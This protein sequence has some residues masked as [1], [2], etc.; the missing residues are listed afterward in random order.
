M[1]Q[2][3]AIAQSPVMPIPLMMSPLATRL[4]LPA[5]ESA[6]TEPTLGSQR[7]EAFYR[8]LSILNF[9]NYFVTLSYQFALIM[10]I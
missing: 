10:S 1:P 8:C 4:S 9:S 6:K 5:I 7:P 3:Q 2:G